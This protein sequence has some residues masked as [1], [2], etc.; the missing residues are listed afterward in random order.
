MNV[1]TNEDEPIGGSPFICNIYDVTKVLVTG[2]GSSKVSHDTGNDQYLKMY[3]TTQCSSGR[4]IHHV[5]GGRK[6]S[7]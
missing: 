7:G 4:P 1:L 3:F 2:L 6:S 5:Y